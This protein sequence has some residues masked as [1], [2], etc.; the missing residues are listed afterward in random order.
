MKRKLQENLNRIHERIARACER[1]DRKPSSVRLVAVTKHASLEMVRAL[2]DL[3]VLDLGESR[4]QDLSQRA[5]MLRESFARRSHESTPLDCVRWHLVGHLQRNK[6]KTVLPWVDTIHSVDSLRLAEDIDTAAGK[7]ERR[8]PILLEVNAADDP[9][10]YG[11]AVAATTHLAEQLATLENIE[12]RGLMAM[13]PLTD[14]QTVIRHTF[15]R[16]RELFDEIVD[17]RT[18]GPAFKQ[19]SL[20]M[21]RDFEHAIEFGATFVRIGTALFDGIELPQ[22]ALADAD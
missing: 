15:E 5:A 12:V 3:G 13:A 1:Y 9:N 7:I 18:M 17:E 21:S 4:V 20:G 14:D 11:V 8:I 6:V 2:I 10:K 19:L 22:R 16:M